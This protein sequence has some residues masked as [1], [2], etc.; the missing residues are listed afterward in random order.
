M[1]AYKSKVEN[2]TLFKRQ[3]SMLIQ[4]RNGVEILLKTVDVTL[5]ILFKIKKLL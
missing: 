4:R 3:S 5:T 2:V 1:V